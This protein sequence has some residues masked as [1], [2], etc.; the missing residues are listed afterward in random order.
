MIDRAK[1]AKGMERVILWSA[2]AALTAIAIIFK[3][4]SWGYDLWWD[5]YVEPRPF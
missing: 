4:T 3:R 1:K 5:L 2:I